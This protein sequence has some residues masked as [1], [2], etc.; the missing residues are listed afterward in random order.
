MQSIQNPELIMKKHFGYDRFRPFQKEAVQTVTRGKDCVCIFPTGA[1]KSL[2]YQ[3]ASLIFPEGVTVVISPL[4]SLME[5]Q[6]SS[7]KSAGIPAERCHSG[8]DE[9]EQ[10]KAVSLAVQ[11]KIRLFYVSPERILSSYFHSILNKMNI[12]LIA[13]DEAH[14]ISAWGQDFRPEYSELHRL[15]GKIISG[16]RPPIL[17]LTATASASV[18]KDISSDLELKNPEIFKSSFFR[19]NL[20]IKIECPENESEKEQ[21]LISALN[22]KKKG[23]AVVYC[24][25]RDKVDSVMKFLKEN[26]LNSS[27]YHAGRKAIDRERTQNRFASGKSDII[28]AT[29]AFG[30]GIDDPDIRTVIH[31]QIPGSI[32]DY[33]QEIGRAGRDGSDSDCILFFE[34]RDSTVRFFLNRK[35]KNRERKDLLFE[36]MRRFAL[37]SS[38]CRFKSVCRYFGEEIEDCGNCDVCTGTVSTE[39]P[40]QIRE[41]L[42][43]VKE[44]REK[45]RSF[46]LSFEEKNYIINTVR[47]HSG[48]LGKKL[49]ALV[50]RGSRSKDILKR[51]L[52][53]S[54]HFSALKHIPEEAI[55]RC[56]EELIGLGKI[57]VAGKKYPRL[58]SPESSSVRKP[59]EKTNVPPPLFRQ[60]K[61]FR[62]AEARKRKWK[63]FMVF[64]N[65]V[66]K[67]ISEEKPETMDDL[68]NIKGMGENK[69]REWGEKILSLVKKSL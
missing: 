42:D 11:G 20:H 18:M 68:M 16:Q 36:E 24:S 65:I 2:I 57:R 47:N 14:C 4:I 13:V 19:K 60:L 44:I 67:R 9:L 1:G 52:E 53:K 55:L 7:L 5:D 17:A 23:K 27:A 30:M 32:E 28:V 15:R 31:Y 12:N 58:C 62:D 50:L 33:Y 48:K 46:E 6:I 22:Q 39:K 35:T 56:M 8:M 38:E 45:N 3:L 25:T 40:L 10:K 26:G 54:E 51:K 63:K 66:L 21:M 49:A 41:R 37:S 69:C 34:N 61:N 43:A 29:N 64:Q 59:A